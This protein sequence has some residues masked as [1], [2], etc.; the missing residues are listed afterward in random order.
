MAPDPADYDLIRD[1][2]SRVVPGFERFNERIKAPDGFTLPNPINSG[3]YNTPSGKAVLSGR[4]PLARLQA[5][6]RNQ[7]SSKPTNWSGSKSPS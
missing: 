6:S 2:V 7:V 3:V 1:R 5:P 4:S